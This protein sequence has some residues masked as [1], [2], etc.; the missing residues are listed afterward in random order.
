MRKRKG[1]ER[2][3]KRSTRKT[4]EIDRDRWQERVKVG[5]RERRDTNHPHIGAFLYISARARS[6]LGTNLGF[7]AAVEK[8]HIK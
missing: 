4:K 6:T 1:G 5:E 8:Q 3:R 2:D 7:H